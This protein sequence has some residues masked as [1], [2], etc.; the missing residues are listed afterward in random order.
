MTTSM[1]NANNNNQFS[2]KA[3]LHMSLLG[4]NIML[5][6]SLAWYLG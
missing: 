2:S 3:L 6:S 5:L 4:L 1:P